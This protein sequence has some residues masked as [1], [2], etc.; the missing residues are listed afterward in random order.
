GHRAL[1]LHHQQLHPD[2]I[3]AW[4]PMLGWGLGLASHAINLFQPFK[5]FGPEWE[6]RQVEKR[7]GRRL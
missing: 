5:L 6:R 2:Y 7:L 3:W 1:P 4:W